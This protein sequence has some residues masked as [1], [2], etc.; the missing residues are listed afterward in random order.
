[1]ARLRYVLV[2][3]TGWIFLMDFHEKS[4]SVVDL[5]PEPYA[6]FLCVYLLQ[7]SGSLLHFA[8][9]VKPVKPSA[10]LEGSPVRKFPFILY[11][12]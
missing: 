10:V 11:A 12:V 1:L 2:T 8:R 9:N 7:V 6:L 4:I 5:L 3:E